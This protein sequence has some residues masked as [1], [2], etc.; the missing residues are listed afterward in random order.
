M[1]N[2][3]TKS[4][5]DRSAHV[6][7]SPSQKR[8]YVERV[9]CGVDLSSTVPIDAEE[10]GASTSSPLP[11][12][13]DPETVFEPSRSRRGVRQPGFFE[14]YR[15]DLLKGCLL[16]VFT[17]M[18]GGVG[19]LAFSL[20]REVGEQKQTPPTIVVKTKRRHP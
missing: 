18:V 12:D 6:G 17:T 3:K 8:A 15:Q 11:T 10:V 19:W 4:T 7:R 14:K 20:N 1:A 5:A 9:V 13:D 2:K 16:F